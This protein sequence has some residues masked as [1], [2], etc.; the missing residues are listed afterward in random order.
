M[1]RSLTKDPMAA[2]IAFNNSKLPDKRAKPVASTPLGIILANIT[3]LGRMIKASVITVPA[4][5]YVVNNRLPLVIEG[6]RLFG[7]LLG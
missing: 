6:S 1:Y 2:D 4:I 5:S 7:I 3:R